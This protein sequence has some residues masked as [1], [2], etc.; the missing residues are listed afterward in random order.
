MTLVLSGCDWGLGSTYSST[1][2]TA[3]IDYYQEACSADGTDMCFRM[4]FDT[5]DEFVVNTLPTSGF[6]GLELGKRYT[7]QVETE[8]DSAGKDS[9]YAFKSTDSEEVVDPAKNNFVLTFSM[10][11]QILLKN[12]DTSWIISAEDIFDCK[13]ADCILLSNSYNANE[14]IQLNFTAADNKLTLIEVKCSAAVNDFESKCEGINKDNWDIAH[15]QSDCISFEPK[16]CLVYRDSDSS[17]NPWHILPFDITG[18]TAAWGTEYELEVKV[19]T[20]SGSIRSAS[21]VSEVSKVDK[22]ADNFIVSM[23]TGVKGLAESKSGLL[24]Y[25]GVTF[26]C[27]QNA[28]CSDVDSAIKK[29]DADSERTIALQVIAKVI[30]EE[31]TLTVEDLICDAKSDD[32]QKDCADKN[33]KIIW[34]E[35]K[36]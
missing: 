6:D 3:Y 24:T 10:S 11:S 12:S 26:N 25:D 22:Q 8:R 9:S 14:K 19:T 32:F 20:S 23:R 34:I 27:D 4:R 16:L 33:D 18:F 21:F 15:Y 2:K 13:E 17:S 7:I 31:L 5:D 28:Q 30:N 1:T 36:K 29:A 35:E